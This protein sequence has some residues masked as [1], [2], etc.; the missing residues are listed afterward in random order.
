MNI[1]YWLSWAVTLSLFGCAAPTR[2]DLVITGGRI[3]DGTGSPWFYGDV[4]IRGDRIVAV[5]RVSADGAR[6]TIDASGLVVAPGFIDM[7]GQSEYAVL[8][9]SSARSKITQGITTEVT[10]EGGSVAPHNKR[11]LEAMREFLTKNDLTVDWRDLDGYFRRLE[12]DGTAINIATFIGATQVRKYVIGFEDRAPNEAELARM[13]ALVE[14]AMRDGALGLSSSLVYAPAYYSTTE[15]LIALA[16]AA[17]RHGGIYATHIRNEGAGIFDALD[18]AVRIGRE[19]RIPVEVWHLKVAGKPN[20][21][22]MPQV[23][24]AIRQARADGVDITADQYPYHASSTSL[25]ST[26]PAW[27]HEG[28]R[29]ALLA[30]LADPATRERLKRAIL[31][32]PDEP[33]AQESFWRGAGGPEGILI[34]SVTN[35]DLKAFE[36]KRLSEVAEERGQDPTDCLFDFLIEDRAA[37]GAI[38]F[39]MSEDDVRLALREPWIAVNCD[40]SA[41]A[42]DG[43]LSHTKPHP[44]AYGSFP[45][46]LGRYV[47][48]EKLLSLETAVAKMT[49]VAAKRV[50]LRDRGQIRQGMAADITIFDPERIIDKAEFGD[51]HHYAEGIVHVLVNGTPVIRNGVITADRPGRALRGPGYVR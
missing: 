17:S 49:W 51:P 31:S 45:R 44:R 20:W 7:L 46:L 18:E 2:Y 48:Q 30:R 10:G 1:R 27:A 28:G 4:G 6:D 23:L 32:G 14:E 25:A 33:S 29:D 36:G 15:E 9:D 40:S 13:V 5:G 42:P 24:D 22:R 11:T 47:R 16:K 8:I 38:Y 26:I 19:A 12:R 34:A 41:A 37:T 50:G 3:V 35:P 39:S 21:G 43:P